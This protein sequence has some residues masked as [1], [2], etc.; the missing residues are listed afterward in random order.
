MNLQSICDPIWPPF[1]G[2]PVNQFEAWWGSIAVL[3][4]TISSRI[5]GRYHDRGCRVLHEQPTPFVHEE[6]SLHLHERR[7]SVS[8]VSFR[9]VWQSSSASSTLVVTLAA[10]VS[11]PANPPCM[12]SIVHR[13]HPLIGFFAD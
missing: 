5:S 4:M 13:P 9:K 12:A 6:L 1:L 8:S 2:L 11:C 7:M 10:A 3:Q